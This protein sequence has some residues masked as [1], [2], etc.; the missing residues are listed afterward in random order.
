MMAESAKGKPR[1]MQ[2]LRRLWRRAG[3]RS[4]RSR[5]DLSTVSTADIWGN[6]GKVPLFLRESGDFQAAMDAVY[7][8][9]E[10]GLLVFGWFFSPLIT[11]LS[12][13]ACS[14]EG[15]E[16]DV[17]PLITELYRKDVID[18]IGP[19]LHAT[20]D[21]HG[22]V[23]VIPLATTQ[24][25]R[26]LLRFDLGPLGQRWL[27]LDTSRRLV[28]GIPLIR[29]ILTRVAAPDR[30][31]ASLFALFEQGLGPVIEHLHRSAVQARPTVNERQ[32]G[33]APDAPRVS[34]I[35]PLYGRFDFVRYQLA[36]FAADPQ[37]REVDLIYVVD[38]P[39]IVSACND[40][41]AHYAP[42]F[43]LPFRLLSY[44]RNLGFAGANNVGVAHARADT[45]VLL[46]S[47]VIPQQPGWLSLLTGI[48]ERDAS[49]GAVGPLLEFGD[50]GLQH[51]G[52]QA[53][54]DESLPGFL[55][56]SHPGKG[57]P[58]N[59]GNAPVE[60]AMLTGACLCMRKADYQGI[61]G[62]DEGYIA[63]DFEDSDL[64][65]ALR[66]NGKSLWLVPEARLWH[67]ERQ[68]Q[69]AQS[70]AGHRQLLTLF[71]A[72]R[73]RY[74]IKTGLIADPERAGN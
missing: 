4:E 37:F 10:H 28:G 53:R 30:I 74:K 62:L 65:M 8:V 23:C 64:C 3:G 36:H 6:H 5:L 59:G 18:T 13:M 27:R 58:W 15:T 50:G 70:I 35:V 71:N 40:F 14:P 56:N 2:Q 16:V 9:G 73:Y 61:G 54:R 25:E 47:D 39:S 60:Q 29:E 20:T 33:R 44:G 32:F 12:I 67:L 42:A 45:V 24:G 43:A 66:K 41:A 63:G 72:W 68:S 57:Q 69:N 49:A 34:V 26:R 38:D 7:P 19:E 17:L 52:M 46:N 1:I 22:F 55:M 11:P 48:L 51:G 31:R 21:I